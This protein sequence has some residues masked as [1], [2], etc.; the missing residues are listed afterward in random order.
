MIKEAKLKETFK[1]M[2]IDANE[3]KDSF[4]RP[5]PRAMGRG[6]L[7]RALS[8]IHRLIEPGQQAVVSPP[9]WNVK[10]FL[11]GF[12]LQLLVPPA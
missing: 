12:S 11:F 10:A 3:T 6:V 7:P 4:L 9:L 2:M 8:V 1:Q 5:R